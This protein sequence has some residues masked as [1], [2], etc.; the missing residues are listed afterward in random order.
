[1]PEEKQEGLVEGAEEL[2]NQPEEEIVEVDPA[3]LISKLE[4]YEST[5]QQLQQQIQQ[6]QQVKPAQAD[7]DSDYVEIPEPESVFES[8]D[9]DELEAMPRKRLVQLVVEEAKNKIAAEVLPEVLSDLEDQLNTLTQGQ[10]LLYVKAQIDE[11]RAKY[12]D[13][14]D[15]RE[16]ILTLSQQYP[17]LPAEELY[18]LA[19]YGA[20]SAPAPQ[21]R[22]QPPRPRRAVTFKT[23]EK[24]KSVKKREAYTSYRDA[25][26]EAWDEVMGG[27]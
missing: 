15:Y 27:K 23:P 14:D 26:N 2:E 10:M 22:S 12:P 25:L 1:M 21:P 5:I 4:Q 16:H 24:P 20:Q 6:L 18:K 19:K 8:L 11:A 17:D 13:F 9:E 3:E 7:D